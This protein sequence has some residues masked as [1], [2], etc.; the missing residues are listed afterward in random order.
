[1]KSWWWLCSPAYEQNLIIAIISLK[2]SQI[3]AVALT[4]KR[5]RVRQIAIAKNYSVHNN[6]PKTYHLGMSSGF[7]SR[8][9]GISFCSI[10]IKQKSD[11]ISSVSTEPV[12]KIRGC[13]QKYDSQV[14][15]CTYNTCKPRSH[16]HAL[17][18]TNKV[19][20]LKRFNCQDA[21][22]T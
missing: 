16:L 10:W 11:V 15:L 19:Q 17:T 14:S 1:M 4:W 3:H 8:H 21:N 22:N 7:I 6:C 13:A 9:K 2:I 5:L 20:N 18:C 12:S